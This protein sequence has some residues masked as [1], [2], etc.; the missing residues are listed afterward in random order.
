[1]SALATS[2][3][4]VTARPTI[5]G[6]ALL[7]IALAACGGS[8]KPPTIP[9]N[10]AEQAPA[11]TAVQTDQGAQIGI[12]DKPSSAPG[13]GST[14]AAPA[15]ERPKM[16]DA[17]AGV[18]MRALQ[19]FALG[20]LAGAKA[21]FQQ[22]ISADPKAFQAHYSLGVVLE[23]LDDGASALAEYRQAISIVPDYEP[24][25]VAHALLQARRGSPS[26]AEAFLN[27]KRASM[28]NSA[29]V[30]AA[31]AE[32]KSM[33]RDS[34]S[35]QQLAQEALKKNSNYPPAMV[36]LA[37]DHYR[38]R[39]LDLAL[40]ALQ[41]ILD[42]FGDDNPARDKDNAEA[43]YL[44]ALIWKEEGNRK[45]ALAEFK[46]VV[47]LRPDIVD[48]RIAL[49]E[50]YLDAGNANDALP[51]L[52]GA[53]KYD[54]NR[55]TAHLALGDCYRLMLRVPEAKAQFDWVMQHDQSIAQV[56]Y[57]LAL[58]YLFSPSVPGMDAKAQAN[59]AITEIDK[60]QQ[61]RGKSAKGTEDDSDE[62]RNRAKQK[63]AD[64][65]AQA[66]ASAPAPAPTGSAAT[67]GDGGAPNGGGDE[68]P[69]P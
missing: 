43:H 13:D 41:A 58:L 40:Y 42:G 64:I 25:I 52:E 6:G 32:I 46:R 30:L 56:H 47:E 36:T 57:D 3:R 7:A 33:Q 2:G 28:S 24:A 8:P 20:D 48:A 4:A 60:Y 67:A 63:I 38:N 14:P 68:T 27:S 22:A 53:L 34:A 31:L 23:R 15:S 45:G 62:L 44:R 11:G 39:R 37:R 50:Y 19:S 51:L 12:T 65:E 61:M 1:M 49:A 66:A 17:A 5:L 29:A 35:A 16:S 59:A 21:L 26:D 69:S 18:Y 9:Q 55:V 54:A 10:A